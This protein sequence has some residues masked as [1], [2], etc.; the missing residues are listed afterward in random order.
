MSRPEIK[1]TYMNHPKT[2]VAGYLVVAAAV[3]SFIAKFMS[4]GIDATS[5]QEIIAALAGVGL[6]ASSDGGA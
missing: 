1:E 3:I 4:G 2:T 6:V 5:I